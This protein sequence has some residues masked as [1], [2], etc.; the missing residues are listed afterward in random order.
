MSELTDHQPPVTRKGFMLRG[1]SRTFTLFLVLASPIVIGDDLNKAFIEGKKEAELG[2]SSSL[3]VRTKNAVKAQVDQLDKVD[4][5][6]L[7]ET[8]YQVLQESQCSWYFV[9]HSL[10]GN[11]P[12]Q[13]PTLATPE[14]KLTPGAPD[15][16][17]KGR[18]MAMAPTGSKPAAPQALVLPPSVHF[19]E[20]AGGTNQSPVNSDLN[21]VNSGKPGGGRTRLPMMALQIAPGTPISPKSTSI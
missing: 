18:E 15:A 12:T 4:P 6:G 21:E 1:I 14:I 10:N 7:G 2:I 13:H 17:E 11:S 19:H 8:Y 16:V 9:C 5:M 20:P 3:A